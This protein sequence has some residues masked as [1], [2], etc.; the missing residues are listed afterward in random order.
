MEKEKKLLFMPFLDRGREESLVK[1]SI[2]MSDTSRTSPLLAQKKR[3]GK[4]P[5]LYEEGTGFPSRNRKLPSGGRQK[6]GEKVSIV[7]QKNHARDS[8]SRKVRASRCKV[9]EGGRDLCFEGEK[10]FCFAVTGVSRS[11]EEGKGGE[12]R[13]W[14]KKKHETVKRGGLTRLGEEKKIVPIWGKVLPEERKRHVDAFLAKRD[15]S[16]KKNPGRGPPNF[17]FRGR[18]KCS[19][20][21]GPLP[22][23][24]LC[25]FR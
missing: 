22:R 7:Y 23:K 11:E 6:K 10:N 4:P 18:K 13:S 20:G 8:P 14:S 19:N 9:E 15:A 25:A 5:T 24:K 16:A 17:R 1:E 2:I 3:R 12:S 21:K